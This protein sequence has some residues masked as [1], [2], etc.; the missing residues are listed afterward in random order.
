MSA[1]AP[2]S[3]VLLLGGGVLL[4][5]AGLR[6]RRSRGMRRLHEVLA[7]GAPDRERP[8]LAVL[9][10][11]L[12]R[13]ADAVVGRRDVDARLAALLER[14]GWALR[15][16]EF[17]VAVAGAG[18]LGA[19]AGLFIAGTVFAAAFLG[20]VGAGG[21]AAVPALRGR[22]LAATVDRQLPDALA[23]I[24]SAMRAGHALG[25]AIEAAA[26]QTPAPLG[27]QLARVTAE[28]RIGRGLH[29]ALEA[30]AERVG[31]VDLRW[32]VKAMSIQTR[33]GGRLAPVLDTLAEFMRER[34]EVRREV[35]ALT[36]DGRMSGAILLAL[37]FF[38]TGA[39][40][41]VRPGYLSPLLTTPAGRVLLAG[42]I[43]AMSVAWVL[44]RKMVRVEV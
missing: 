38:V 2:V 35:R 33:T 20:L 44:I 29:E 15:P 12:T 5:L 40:M 8:E 4:V 13:A 37:P 30:M 17:V 23:R 18:L 36:A 31:S 19:L 7:E 21:L 3:A 25:A 9:W 28:V 1:L 22:R 16:G 6:S 43:G 14:A 42:G 10:A 32:S 24:A 39:L 11:R 34:E 41:L 26:E 27:T